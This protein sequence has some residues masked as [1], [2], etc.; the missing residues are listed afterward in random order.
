MASAREK[1]EKAR[2]NCVCSCVKSQS[3]DLQCF[4]VL[5]VLSA[6]SH[7]NG[8]TEI[9]EEWLLTCLVE[10]VTSSYL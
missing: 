2:S 8:Y 6:S 3:D 1:R 9:M 10:V 4:P 7:Q 5:A